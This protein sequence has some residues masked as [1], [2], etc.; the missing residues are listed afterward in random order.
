MNCQLASTNVFLGGQ[1]QWDL[2]VSSMDS[3]NL[4]V[5]DFH[6]SPIS[7]YI[8][9]QYNQDS[10]LL[11]YKHLENVK[12]LYERLKGNFFKNS[13]NPKL[14]TLYPTHFNN[15]D[16]PYENTYHCGVKRMKYQ[17][18]GTQFHA[19]CPLWIED[20]DV[21]TQDIN[22]Y[23]RLYTLVEQTEKDNTKVLT[24]KTI[25]SRK[26]CLTECTGNRN[27]HT[28]FS[29]YLKEYL[30][31]IETN[32]NVCSIDFLT[33][34]S[35]IRGVNVEKG[36]TETKDTSYLVNNILERER[37]LLEFNSMLTNQFS[38][39]KIVARQLFN[40]NVCFNIYDIVPV[41][42]L[43]SI[44]DNLTTVNIEVTA[45]INNKNSQVVNTLDFKD[46][47]TNHEYINRLQL[48]E[49]RTNKEINCLDYLQDN[50]CID[51]IDKNKIS[52]QICHWSLLD[53]SEYVFQ[54]YDGFAPIY[55]DEKGNI[56]KTSHKYY[57]MPDVW[58]NINTNYNNSYGW[59]NVTWNSIDEIFAD[60]SQLAGK[61]YQ[62]LN[63]TEFKYGQVFYANSLKYNTTNLDK[64]DSIYVNIIIDDNKLKGVQGYNE[65]YN[66]K[67]NETSTDIIMSCN[68]TQNYLTF[69]VFNKKESF[70]ILNYKNFIQTDFTKDLFIEEKNDN[71][72]NTIKYLQEILK[73][74][75]KPKIVFFNKGLNIKSAN[76]PD[77]ETGSNS[78]VEIEYTKKDNI[79]QYLIRYDGKIRPCMISYNSKLY[80]NYLYYKLSDKSNELDVYNKYIPTKFPPLYPSLNY[81]AIKKI[82]EIDFNKPSLLPYID[83][84]SFTDE[85]KLNNFKLNNLE[86]SWYNHSQIYSLRTNITFNI[87]D[88]IKDE[89]ELITKIKKQLGKIYNISNETETDEIIIEYIYKQYEVLYDWEYTDFIKNNTN[90]NFDYKY[91]Y[92]INLNLK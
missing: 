76:R 90:T 4:C 9:F 18:Y 16:Y 37:P 57:N 67:K 63:Y 88:N 15:Y 84:D 59:C 21:D 91:I 43:K 39:N 11:N 50:K 66:I 12:R 45:E 42:L 71:V 55:A 3:T 62:L 8:D 89:D 36:V 13:Y 10:D 70:E 30:R 79:N 19:F 44:I 56:T 65:W 61:F 2:I 68:L 14:S 82:E 46:F 80:N 54:L 25:S 40:F 69:V 1:M 78:D 86:Y 74:L 48:G 53:D 26:L 31:L 34:E 6:L 28:K 33:K 81:F 75:E 41:M 87:E 24:K 22:I 52:P 23:I 73:T 35:W 38:A 85:D 5:T 47:F 17:R 27:Y 29:E 77:V 58:S 7:E 51:F 72:I 83:D 60:S 32:D 64:K 20:F 92:T 49:Y